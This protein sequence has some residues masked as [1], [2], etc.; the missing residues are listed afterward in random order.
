VISQ[1]GSVR[2]VCQKDGRVTHW[3]QE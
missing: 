3:E 1:D 2:F